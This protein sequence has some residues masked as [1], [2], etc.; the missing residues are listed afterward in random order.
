MEEGKGRRGCLQSWLDA[1]VRCM[2]VF[3]LRNFDNE[4]GTAN[5]TTNTKVTGHVPVFQIHSPLG[6][7]TLQEMEQRSR[8]EVI[9]VNS[10]CPNTGRGYQ[11]I[12]RFP[13]LEM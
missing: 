9:Q 6:L 1:V 13:A 4:G 7:S 10:L 11:N 12:S 2:V 8:S 3:N 5:C